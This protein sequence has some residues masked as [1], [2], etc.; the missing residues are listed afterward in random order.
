MLPA[1]AKLSVY[2][3]RE[4]KQ[5]LTTKLSYLTTNWPDLCH[6]YMNS[7]HFNKNSIAT[8]MGRNGAVVGQVPHFGPFPFNKFSKRGA[9]KGGKP[10][11]AKSGFQR[12]K[13]FLI[14]K[15][16]CRVLR[17]KEALGRVWWLNT[18]T[19]SAEIWTGFLSR[20]LGW[21]IWPQ[22]SWTI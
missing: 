6:F 9:K 8:K 15:E 22:T 5:H 3:R 19:F 18:Y 20:P 7:L 4:P 14:I 11:S 1:G 21:S 12:V 10:S 2:P 13:R 16:S 17:W